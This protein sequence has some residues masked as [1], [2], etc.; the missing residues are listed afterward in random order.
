[1]VR[2][3]PLFPPADV[4]AGRSPGRGSGDAHR[5]CGSGAADT[6]APTGPAAVKLSAGTLVKDGQITYCSDISAP[7]LTYYDAPQK[8]VG[9]EI[10]L[11]N[12]LAAQLGVSANWANTG[13]N[14]IIPALQAKQCDAIVSQLYIKPEREKVVDFVPYMYAS[15]TLLVTQEGAKDV[16]SADDLCGKKAAGQTGTTIV[17]YLTDQST[18][19]TAAG[20]AKIDI[21]QFTKDSDALQQLA[22]ASSTPTARPSRAPPTPS[23]SS[24]APSRWSANRS[25]A[26]RSAP[27]PARTTRPCTRR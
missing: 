23:S 16:K 3:F 19:C 22:S 17:E 15:N 11:G 20:K 25:T 9:A 4:R 21:R 26:S 8:P 12:A 7:P 18:K 24:R 10:E 13:F 14:G 6:P 5:L 27:P 1:M 2:S